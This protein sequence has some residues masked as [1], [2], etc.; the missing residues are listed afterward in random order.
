MADR[1]YINLNCAAGSSLPGVPG[2]DLPLAS[3][4]DSR[5]QN[6]VDHAN[7]YKLS[8][9]RLVIDGAGRALPLGYASIQTGQPNPNLTVWGFSPSITLLGGSWFPIGSNIV[10]P[11]S[12][13][14]E[15]GFLVRTQLNAAPQS[16]ATI[17]IPPATYTTTTYAAQVTALLAALAD[18]VLNQITCSVLSPSGCLTF[19]LAAGAQAPGLQF[20]FVSQGYPYTLG[21]PDGTANG[22]ALWS[23]PTTFTLSFPNSLGNPTNIRLWTSTPF[24][25]Y[26]EFSPEDLSQQ[27]P[28]APTTV[29]TESAY[30]W[31]YSYQAFCN[32]FNVASVKAMAT[33]NAQF[34]V[35]WLAQAFTTPFPGLATK[36]PTLSYDPTSHLFTLNG[37]LWSCGP[38][39]TS[40][41]FY[42]PTPSEK[43]SI[44]LL[45]QLADL[46]CF[47]GNFD[48]SGSTIIEWDSKGA[49]TQEYVSTASLMCP[50]QSIAV[51]SSLLP[52]VPEGVSPPQLLGSGIPSG[53]PSTPTEAQVTDFSITLSEASDWKA[54]QLFYSP[55]A[56]YRWCELSSGGPIR[57]IDLRLAWRNRLTGSLVPLQLPPNSSIS[58]KL[59]LQRRD[60][61]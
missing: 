60:I 43:F 29:Q 24:T 59:L 18:P 20:A 46:F 44:S 47:K 37:D 50:V 57:Q 58:C 36:A 1:V 27:V 39:R 14:Q 17:T 25:Q 11:A 28:P 15:L 55:A 38:S 6:I 52:V 30:Y 54:G 19:K 31:I 48:V 49:C 5:S 33:L 53:V 4:T 7:E 9:L 23:D 41:P 13:P 16:T 35:W 10:V 40:A 42:A 45:E 61:P 21:L 32:M 2:A 56:E 3:Y 26:L 22:G 12:P 34:A 8:V 51:L